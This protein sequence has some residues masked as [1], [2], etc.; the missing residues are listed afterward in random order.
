MGDFNADVNRSHKY[1]IEEITDEDERRARNSKQR[2]Y[3]ND[4]W[5]AS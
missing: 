3:N 2:D 5:L 4:K 1:T